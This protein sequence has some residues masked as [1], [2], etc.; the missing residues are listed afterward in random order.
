MLRPTRLRLT[1]C[2]T[3]LATTALLGTLLAPSASA[4]AVRSDLLP[5]PA[6]STGSAQGHVP[7]TPPFGRKI[8]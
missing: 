1:A 7:A 3:T 4:N 6:L 2:T 5:E 8:S